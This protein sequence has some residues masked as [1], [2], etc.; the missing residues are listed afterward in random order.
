MASM[1]TDL[2]RGRVIGGQ[3]FRRGWYRLDFWSVR[4]KIESNTVHDNMKKDTK[5]GRNNVEQNSRH[6]TGKRN[7]ELKREAAQMNFFGCCVHNLF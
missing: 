4:H 1:D 6:N 2:V 7:D 5:P 3:L